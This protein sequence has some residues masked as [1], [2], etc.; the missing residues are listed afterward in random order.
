M[1]LQARHHSYTMPAVL[2]I[3]MEKSTKTS[4][5]STALKNATIT[6]L[7]A[8]IE[9]YRADERAGV[10]KLIIGAE[11]R[12]EAHNKEVER[13]REMYHYERLY[14]E[15]K[16]IAGVDEVGRG[17]FAG[18]VLTCAAILPKNCDILY[19]NDSKQLSAAKR[20]ELF[21]VLTKE[22][23]AY[24]IATRDN[25]RIDEI[26]ILQATLEAM[27]EAV[28]GL[29]TPADQLLVD[30][31]IIPGIKTDQR[32]IEH[33]DALSASI[34]AA[35]IIAKVTRD[36]MMMELDKIYPEYGFAKNKGYG[37]ADHIAALKKY[38]PCPIHRRSFIHSFV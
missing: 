5:I 18:P 13:M 30:A 14:P 3:K 21:A 22:C 10:Q 38:G 12:I 35:S 23:V 7:P 8:L 26:N 25:L 19:I 20:E 9:L 32:K 33:G 36:H 4:E 1:T 16:A 17:C 2:H 11:K 31:A 27:K 15:K 34:A 6:E 24:S 28:E 37:T 29:K